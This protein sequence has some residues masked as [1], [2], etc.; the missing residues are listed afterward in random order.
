M[1]SPLSSIKFKLTLWN[2]A[3]LIFIN[4]VFL[5]GINGV[6]TFYY[7]QDPFAEST[8]PFWHESPLREWNPIRQ[9]QEIILEAREDDLETIRMISLYTLFPLVGLSIVGGYI[10]S[11]QMLRPLGKLNATMS[12]VT[13]EKLTDTID[14]EDTG[15]EISDLIENFNSMISRLNTSFSSQRKFVENAAHELKTPLTIIQTN[16]DALSSGASLTEKERNEMVTATTEASSFMSALIDD[17]LLLSLLNQDIP[18]EKFSLN[19]LLE[20]TAAQLAVIASENSITLKP[21]IPKREYTTS[22]NEILIQRSLMNLLENA[23]KYS[24]KG[25]EI[26]VTLNK[27]GDTAAISVWDNAPKIPEEERE[28]IFERFYRI[29][30]SRSRQTGGSGLGLSIA[31]EV[32]EAHGGSISMR[33]AKRGNVFVLSLPLSTN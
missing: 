2:S 15:D 13:S 22:G 30:K 6:I 32:A 8:G 10:I 21:K 11:D 33:R 20:K 23:I 29:D 17:L 4:F 31:R 25:S 5:I 27:K 18:K 24:P 19:S 28:K 16:L 12:K 26:R 7:N 3:L 9:H 14:H 1:R